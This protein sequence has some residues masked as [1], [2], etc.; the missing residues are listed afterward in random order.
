MNY[1]LL[2]EKALQ[3]AAI[4]QS[5]AETLKSKEEKSFHGQMQQMVEEPTNK[6]FLTELIDKSFRPQNPY[7]T[8]DLI[9]GVI[10]RYGVPS[11]FSPV[12]RMLM[13]LFRAFGKL[14]APLAVG[15]VID[16]IR[17]K[18]SLA[19]LHGG[20]TEIVNHVT[21]RS[22]ESAKV[23]LN[24]I[25]E[26]VLSEEEA[27]KKLDDYLVA[28][29]VP[30]VNYLSIKISNIYSQISALD[31][32][33]TVD[34]LVDRLS[35]VYR[36]AMANTDAAGQVKF[37]NLDMEEYRD[38][39]MT[40]ALFKRTLDLPEFKNLSAGIVLQAYLPD[41]YACLEDLTEWAVERVKSGG[42]PIKV[43]LVKGANMD[44]E[45]T[46][47]STK[48]W[49]QAP[50]DSKVATD[51]NYKKMLTYLL[52]EG[53]TEAVR[54]GLASHNIFEIAFAYELAHEKGCL[55]S[56]DFEM[57]EGMADGTRKVLQE[58]GISV[59]L[60]T[61]VA[62]EDHFIN[63]IAYFVRRLDENTAPDN[64]LTHSFALDTGSEAWN[65]L[66]GQFLK[67]ISMMSTIDSAPRHKQ[68]RLQPEE[69]K[70]TV[71]AFVSEPDTNWNLP[72]NRQWAEEVREDW[73][74]EEGDELQHIP[75]VINGQELLNRNTHK[76]L[77]ANTKVPIGD[78]AIC[79]QT[80]IDAALTVAK[81]NEEWSSKSNEERAQI[82][83]RAAAVL[84]E[85]R[86][87]LIGVA[88][89]EV[90]KTFM[91]TDA[92]ISEAIDFAEYYPRS[93]KEFTSR[94]NIE[95]SSR[96]VGLI[97][98]PWN[99]PIAIP[100]GGIVSS[101]VAGNNTV[102]KPAPQSVYCAYLLCQAFWK[103]G[104]PKSA[105][106]FLLADN[107]PEGTYLIKHPSVDF[108]IFTGSTQT[109]LFMLNERPD[110]PLYAETGGKNA[111][112][113]TAAADRDAAIK[114]VLHSAFGNSG[115]KCSATS[116]LLLE[117][118][119]F[120][121]ESFK[122]NLVESVKSLHV[123]SAWDFSTKVG[124]LANPYSGNLKTLM[125]QMSAED[126]L[127]QPL[128]DGEND[129][130]LSPGIIWGVDEDHFA[131]KN[132]L[133]AP[134][135]C[136]MQVD[137]LEHAIQVVNNS[138]YG[139]TSGLETL[140]E[141]EVNLWKETLDAGNLYINRPTTGAIVLRQPFGGYKKSS[142]GGG[143]K[144][145]GPNYVQQ[146]TSIKETGYPVYQNH[147]HLSVHEISEFCAR[148]SSSPWMDKL[149]CDK[150]IAGTASYAFEYEKVFSQQ[151]DY[152]KVRGEENIFR[153]KSLNSLLLVL[154]ASRLLESALI[155]SAASFSNADISV[156]IDPADNQEGVEL[157]EAFV[158]EALKPFYP[159]KFELSD[160]NIYDL[161][162]HLDRFE[163]V[164]FVSEELVS[165]MVQSKANKEGKY[166][167]T[168]KPYLD[169]RLELLHY[170][171]EQSISYAYHRYG[172][173]GI[174]GI[175]KQ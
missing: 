159:S 88:T 10:H 137:S 49:E 100:A 79:T 21:K 5:K 56:I 77:D 111:T 69:E 172:N 84:R 4:W 175:N 127:F 144:A 148:N 136:V 135:L 98:P 22:E 173:L 92:E 155:L 104:V 140:D 169:G 9:N 86:G 17:A 97:V 58:A 25:G 117:K 43:R 73:K 122:H 64:F 165:V 72:A 167:F 124:P 63:A 45:Q 81:E 6:V 67:S 170:F 90:G 12:E 157:L 46:E 52:D 60:Y 110:L 142:I 162:L 141:N 156:I 89:A 99:F 143:I 146:F 119:V 103:A 50:F 80:D 102:I 28:L 139:L 71:E 150:L 82:M 70:A 78:Y 40:I 41:S 131:W 95:L 128:Y 76:I 11:M 16:Q 87:D 59:L 8:A 85:M 2:A 7:R 116:L 38:L 101:L 161:H 23:N 29:A 164:R 107:N 30:E 129:K 94:E 39:E 34:V 130:I 125:D 132:E 158:H 120:E 57:L 3:R 33:P 13:H 66:Q 42:A 32:E 109:G 61:P 83:Y 121:D 154:D 152:F 44:M 114:N 35:E 54:I 91:E 138:D 65:M 149:S 105:L 14:T 108:V 134:V 53:R 145:G 151:Q 171:K 19:I 37:V 126:W 27:L 24:L 74:K 47:A 26:V 68:N 115:Q 75:V 93:I 55:A 163:R 62:A 133:F 96:G 112:I 168:Q 160:I 118:E 166:L 20:H 36:V 1:Q 48:H 147:K 31:F 153:Y 51:A 15:Q 113:V 18:T 106:Q 174:R 123:G